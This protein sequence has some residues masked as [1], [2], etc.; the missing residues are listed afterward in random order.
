[1]LLLAS[2]LACP[3]T[4]GDDSSGALDD[5]STTVTDS[6]EVTVLPEAD[7]PRVL[8]NE[9]VAANSSTL[10][11]GTGAWS[12][13]IELYN[14]SDVTV[15]LADWTLSDDPDNPDDHT[16]ESFLLAPGEHLLLWADNDLSLGPDHLDFSLARAGGTLLLSGPDGR[17]VDE[18]DYP[19]QATDV[20]AAR[21]GDGG[22]AWVLT[23]EPTPGSANT[24]QGVVAADPSAPEG[25]CGPV[26]DLAQPYFLEG[27]SVGFSVTCGGSLSQAD[28]ELILLGLPEG[29]AFDEAGLSLSWDTGPASGGRHD[30]VFS[31]RAAGA[32]DRVP[33]ASTVTFWV[34]D[35][36]DIAGAVAVDPLTYT[37]E[38]GLPVFHLTYEGSL[39][40]SYTAGETTYRGETYPHEIKIRGAASA[41][42]PKNSWTVK[43]DEPEI[44]VED[45]GRSRDR[46]VFLTTFDD[47]SFVRQKLIY[48][49][50]A[51]MA[52]HAGES[53]LTPRTFFGVVYLQGVYHGLY[54]IVDHVDNEFVDHFGLNRDGNLYKSV[55][56][57]ANFE[58][59]DYYGNTKSSLHSGYE[60]KEGDPSDD[61][62]D[63]DSLVAWS[64]PAP[65]ATILAEAEDWFPLGE[66]QDWFLLVYYSLSE[67]SAGKNA[68]L[69]NDPTQATRFRYVP[70]D[71]NHAWGQNWYTAR[72]SSDAL[73]DYFH[74]NR[75]FWAMQT[76]PAGQTA[77]WDRF[78][79]LRETGPLGLEWQLATLDEYFALIEPSAERDW[80]RWAY[81]YH[82]EWWAGYRESDW[83][84]YQEEKAYL[85]DWVEERA[86]LFEVLVP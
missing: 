22:E 79:N 72:T 50:W 13:W 59:T 41:G 36:P 35:N 47:N 25:T 64:G 1:M 33:A 84:T 11:D 60:K 46:L 77:L 48:D 76:D 51:A 45:W 30:L 31:D 44:E 27:D 66:F 29:A 69:Y 58:L 37:E 62:S 21:S 7:W 70:W 80:A 49:V 3:A 55:N 57:D 18:V 28:A 82:H 56:H 81:D 6:G 73:N 43:Y 14:A 32:T 65:A 54:V 9:F 83:T 10:A 34:A 16:L 19:N 38:W 86:A 74:V 67:D 75:L 53:R 24:D 85:Y 23:L 61:F 20:A 78:R 26:S 40:E 63:L 39:T 2:L 12:D 17:V 15:D 71:F 4:V 8:I 68:Y 42:Y 5:T 52:D